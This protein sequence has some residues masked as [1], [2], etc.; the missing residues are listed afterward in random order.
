MNKAILILLLVI[1]SFTM[2]CALQFESQKML[3]S[4]TTQ[5]PVEPTPPAVTAAPELEPAQ[6]EKVETAP[7]EQSMTF[8]EEQ[9]RAIDAAKEFV[10]SLD[11]Y[12]DQGGR[13]LQALNSVKSGCVGC[14]IVEITF[15]RNLLYYPDKTEHI[16][17]NVELKNWKMSA[18]TF[19]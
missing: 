11:G 19:G 6:V 3:T 7:K 4:P 2:G 18:Y 9:D 16:R 15:T 1:I 14:W 5:T 13:E 10:Q 12:K 17:V 8:D